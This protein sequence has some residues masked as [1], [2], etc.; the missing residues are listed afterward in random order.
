MKV[1]IGCDHAGFNLKQYLVKELTNEGYEILDC[2]T[3]SEKSVDYP[4]IGAIIANGISS[5]AYNRGILICGTGIGM[6]IV[7]NRFRGVRGALCHDHYTATMSRK[8]NDANVL[9]LGG[10]TTGKGLARS[11]VEAWLMTDFEGGRHQ[12]RLDRIET[13]EKE[14]IEKERRTP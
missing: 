3:D 2:G 6:S 12:R 4:D 14:I 13:I 10:R 5:K 11:M 8:H 1:A 9:I 7:V